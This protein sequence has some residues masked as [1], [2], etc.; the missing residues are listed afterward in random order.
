MGNLTCNKDDNCKECKNWCSD[1][2]EYMKDKQ[3]TKLSSQGRIY[4][5]A[6]G[7]AMKEIR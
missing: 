4:K 1:Y 7:G 6:K 5:R 3:I 2:E